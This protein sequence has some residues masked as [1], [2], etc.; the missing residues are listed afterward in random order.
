MS[1]LCHASSGRRLLTALLLAFLAV[2]G[3]RCDDPSLS[4]ALPPGAIID[5]FAQAEVSRIDIL[6]VIDDS[7]SMT[8]E[9]Q[10]LADNLSSFHR[11]LDEGDVDYQIGVTTTDAVSNAGRLVGS[12]TLLSPTTPDVFTAFQQNIRVGITGRAQEQGLQA[13][14]L[15]LGGQNPGFVREDAHLFVIFV[16]DEDDHSFGELRYYWRVFEQLKGIGN[17]DTVSLSAI[18]GPPNDP[19]SGEGGGCSS[20][21]GVASP[22]DRYALLTEETGGIFGSICDASFADTLDALGAKA[23]GLKRKFFLSYEPDPDTIEVYLHFDCDEI[24]ADLGECGEVQDS[25]GAS[26]AE[27]QD[28]FCTPPEGPNDGWV[29]E[30]ETN[31]IFFMGSSVPPLK[32]TVEVIYLQPKDPLTR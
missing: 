20:T 12:P 14:E 26:R 10:N 8:E 21:A 22:G 16:S 5:T 7:A 6:W 28:F 24:P 4:R 25:C 1:H 17:E 31:S 29:Y 19:V 13:A 27:D 11:F 9:Q 15:A 23:V 3:C 2:G 18:I 30:S 32:A